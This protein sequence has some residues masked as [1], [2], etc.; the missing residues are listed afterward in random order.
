VELP[1][2]SSLGDESL[3]SGFLSGFLLD[4]FYCWDFLLIPGGF[5]F[6]F[7]RSGEAMLIEQL[8]P[9]CYVDRTRL[10]AKL[11]G[12]FPG[13]DEDGNPRFKVQVC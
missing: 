5:I 7:F 1:G 8:L 13:V 6:L 4:S 11:R 2:D 3:A 9:S 10:L 12:R